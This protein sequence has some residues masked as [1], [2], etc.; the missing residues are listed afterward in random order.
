MDLVLKCYPDAGIL[1]V[2]LEGGS[3]VDEGWLD[4]RRC[5]GL[6]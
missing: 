6:R 4:R 5:G 3:I 2:E 1:V